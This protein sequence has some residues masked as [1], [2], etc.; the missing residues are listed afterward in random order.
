[1]MTEVAT[2]AYANDSLIA[3]DS[4]VKEISQVSLHA[5]KRGPIVEQTIQG[6]SD[7]SFVRLNNLYDYLTDEFT[8]AEILHLS[9]EDEL[10]RG[11][12]DTEAFGELIDDARLME[13]PPLNTDIKKVAHLKDKH[14][15]ISNFDVVRKTS[16]SERIV[17]LEWI[18]SLVGMC[19]ISFMPLGIY[20]FQKAA[21]A[22]KNAE[23]VRTAY[24]E[25]EIPNRR[26][27]RESSGD[28]GRQYAGG[29]PLV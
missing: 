27:N 18:I 24:Q 16:F 14:L 5:D 17:W 15:I 4:L 22:S 7:I 9:I 19:R 8:A 10:K 3:K 11:R 6:L 2:V 25:L 28:I 12:M 13:I 1:M 26:T 29:D 21:I 20:N 23:E